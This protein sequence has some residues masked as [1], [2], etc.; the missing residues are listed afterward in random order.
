MFKSRPVVNVATQAVFD[1]TNIDLAKDRYNTSDGV[2]HPAIGLRVAIKYSG[3]GLPN[4]LGKSKV[5]LLLALA[6]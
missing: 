4:S 2:H 1:K 3:V 6:A 5:R